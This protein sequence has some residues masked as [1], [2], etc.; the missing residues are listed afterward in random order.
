MTE[1]SELVERYLGVFFRH[2][3]QSAPNSATADNARRAAESLVDAVREEG[4]QE[5]RAR[6]MTEPSERDRELRDETFLAFNPQAHRH[7]VLIAVATAREEGRQEER[8]WIVQLII[9]ISRETVS[10]DDAH[11]L[12]FELVD[13]VRENERRATSAVKDS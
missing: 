11:A 5:E 4:R 8:A 12:C 10:E 3:E 2:L 1:R 13:A 6:C 7:A 9:D